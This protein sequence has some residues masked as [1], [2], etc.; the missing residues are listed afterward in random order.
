MSCIPCVREL[1][2]ECEEAFPDKPCCCHKDP[3]AIPLVES[4]GQ[5]TSQAG[6]PKK[7]DNEIGISAGRKRAAELY[8]LYT[9][10]PCEWRWLANC[11]GGKHPILGCLDGKQVNRHHGPVKHTARNEATNVHLICSP[12]HNLWH[13]KN[14]DD[15]SETANEKLPHNP[16]PMTVDELTETR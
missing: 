4:T 9:E 15:Y 8:P 2:E 1:H 13:S 11:G 6:R 3:A 10:K 14:D 7:D 5:S 16:R 12:C